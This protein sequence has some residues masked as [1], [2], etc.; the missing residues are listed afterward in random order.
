MPTFLHAAD[1][2]LD[3]PLRGLERKEG[4]PAERI[5]SASRIAFERL[6]DMAISE[7]VAFVLLAGDIYDT[8][9][10]FETYLY[11]HKQMARL[12]DAGIP[13]AIVLGNHDHGGAA[14]RAGRLPEGVHVLPHEAPASVE[15]VP[16]VWVHGQSYPTRDIADDLTANY[17]PAVP[18]ALNIGLLHTAL[19]GHSGE[20]ARY[21]PSNTQRL[22]N[23]GYA[24]WALGHVHTPLILQEGGCH[25][26]YPGNLQGRHARETGAKGAMFVEYNEGGITGVRHQEF[27]DVRW[28]R[29]ELDAAALDPDQEPVKQVAGEVLQQTS[30]CRIAGRLAAVRIRVAGIAPKALID[31]GEG[32]IRDSLRAAF[33][34]HDDMFLE[35]IELDLH[36]APRDQHEV[37]RYLAALIGT[38]P[39]AAG[40]EDALADAGRDLLE[41]LRK[42]GGPELVEAF[43]ARRAVPDVAA[44]LAAALPLVREALLLRARGGR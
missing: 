39:N 8:E 22:A 5:R 37:D 1:L 29:L 16:G 2:H 36:P 38:M 13:V 6:V 34:T 40:V 11:F 25:I 18:A 26:V 21:A 7:E 42:S 31:L 44:D 9:P 4:A 19:D 28:Y 10:A 43:K 17:P 32:E 30:T 12:A 15:I 3:S 20:H 41:G 24:Y 33:S 14:P 27:D 35:K 23:H